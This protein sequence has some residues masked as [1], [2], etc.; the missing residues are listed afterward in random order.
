MNNDAET[1]L[2]KSLDQT[3]F[4]NEFQDRPDRIHI[5]ET[6]I[7]EAVSTDDLIVQID[8]ASEESS[9]A[10]GEWID[11]LA[12]FDRWLKE[13]GLYATA[14]DQISYLHCVDASIVHPLLTHLKDELWDMLEKHGCQVAKKAE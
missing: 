6:L 10:I 12:V 14:E 13:K 5:V 8:T 4:V 3:V 2:R 11:A 7:Q 1:L 9:Y